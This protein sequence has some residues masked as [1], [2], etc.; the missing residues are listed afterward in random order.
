[1]RQLFRLSKGFVRRRSQPIAAPPDRV[2]LVALLQRHAIDHVLDVGANVGQYAR[3]LRAGG[4]AGRI[5]SFEP[6]AEC[7]AALREASAGDAR[8]TVAPPMALGAEDTN[9]TIHVSHRSDMSSLLP[10]KDVTLQAIPRAFTKGTELVEVRHLGGVFDRFVAA[11]ERVFLKLDTQGSELTVLQ[12]ARPILGR[13]VGLQIELSLLPLYEGE[14]TYLDVLRFVEQ[15]G[16]Q[17]H[18]FLDGYFS[19]RINRQLQMDG[20]FFR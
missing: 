16:F 13:V 4:Y 7:H 1:M 17:P 6:L 5:T 10:I 9:A 3:S 8:W 2:R 14:G 12:G 19:K 20:I 15:G 18:L 11:G